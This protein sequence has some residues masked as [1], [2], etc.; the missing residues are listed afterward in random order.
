M[1]GAVTFD[2]WGTLYVE[3]SAVHHRK[4]LRQDYALGFFMGAGAHVSP[5]QLK[6]AFEIL[7]HDVERM[8]MIS[9]AGV[10]AEEMGQRLARIVGVELSSQDGRRLGEVMSSAACEAPPVPA[11]GAV[12]VLQALH[13]KVRIG[14]ISDTGITQGR[15]LFRVMEADGV[16]RL[17]DH[18]TFSDE[19]GTT[20]PEVRQFH[21]T[22]HRLGVPPERA[23]HVGDLEDSDIVG[24]RQAGMRAI[25][26][27]R[28]ESDPTT[29]ADA[30][31][32]T[33]ADVLNVLGQWGLA[34]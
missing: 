21:Y 1:I 34:L 19:T 32:A 33:I 11:P 10:P 9:H 25:R 28:P 22:L 23:V 2:F 15:D 27:V 6:Y 29:A 16:A 30:A 24:A 14:L 20:K 8:R 31:V 26:L 13:G 12:E 4:Q 7:F 3:G 17:I 5:S 18:F